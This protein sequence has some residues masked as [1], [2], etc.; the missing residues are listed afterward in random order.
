MSRLIRS[1]LASLI[2]AS[3]ASIAA[4]PAALAEPGR[5]TV[6]VSVAY[7][8]LNLANPRGAQ[9]MLH[10]LEAASD[11]ACGGRPA[12]RF[13]K[14]WQQYRACTNEALSKA[15]AEIDAPLVTAL[16]SKDG[17]MNIAAR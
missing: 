1:A 14:Q 4:A 10:R 5:M 3:I 12:P 15:V 13:H 9:T 11:K 17:G 8:D 2:F 7:A 16:F 6:S